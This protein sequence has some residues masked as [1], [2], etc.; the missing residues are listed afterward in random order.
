MKHPT[1]VTACFFLLLIVATTAVAGDAEDAK[2]AF[3]NAINSFNT[4]DYL[5]YSTYIADDIETFTGVVT[6]LRHEGKNHWMDFIR[7]FGK[8]PSVTYHQQD[9]SVRTFNGNSAVINGYFVFTVVASDG[10]P[11]TQSGRASTI[12]VKSGDKWQI[13]NHH[14]SPLF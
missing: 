8:L 2:A 3:D 13:V 9:N 5:T 1:L 7:G 4:K 6:P 14:F 12:L 11:T 10:Q